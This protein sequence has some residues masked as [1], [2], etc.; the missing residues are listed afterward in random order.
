MSE[1]LSPTGVAAIWAAALVVLAVVAVSVIVLVNQKVFGPVQMVK[2]LQSHLVKGEGARAL[3]L[4]NAKVPAGNA[5]LLDGEGLVAATADI[6]DF[7]VG[8]PEEILGAEDT[9]KV[10]ATYSIH[11]VEQQTTY[12]LRHTGRSWMF[13]DDW[14]FVPTTLPTVAI[15]ANTTNE[16]V[17]NSRRAPLVKGQATVPVFVPAVIDTSFET[18]NFM[19]DSRGLAVTDFAKKGTD[20]KLQTQPTKKLMD[21]VNK[22]ITAYLDGCAKQQ[23]LM[24]AGCPMS[25]STSARVQSDSIHWS[26]L[27][28]PAAEVVSFDGGWALR[29][30]TVKA[31]LELTEQD[32]RTGGYTEQTVDDSFGFTAALKANTTKVLVTPVSSE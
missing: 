26:I 14:E 17:V 20:V 13:F 11:G 32:L 19:A 30:L 2:E 4:L 28:Y 29:P 7:T 16:V 18:P 31:R 10:V 8:K 22:Q 12:Q 24:P 21:E 3:G 5:L 15:S 23:V 1:R 6:K 25:Y 9:V 27:D